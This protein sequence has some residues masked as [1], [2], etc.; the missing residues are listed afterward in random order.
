MIPSPV[1][2]GHLLMLAGLL[3]ALYGAWQLVLFLRSGHGPGTPL[4][5]R[6]RDGRRRA[7]YAIAAAVLLLAAGCLS[8][9]G[10]VTIA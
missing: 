2:L 7:V 10:Q 1:T 3:A 9:L 4:Y 6:A 8:P 5:A